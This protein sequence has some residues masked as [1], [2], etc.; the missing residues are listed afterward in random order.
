[1]S[2]L[3]VWV[4]DLARQ[5]A[6]SIKLSRDEARHVTARRLR[7]GD[8]LIV[9][10]GSGRT[11]EA[12][13]ESTTQRSVV[14]RVDLIGET[15]RLDSGFVI[16]SAIPKGDRLGTMLQML[17]QLGLGV[18]QPLIL[19]DSAI[20][21]LDPRTARLQR[22]CL[23]SAK[24]ARRPWRLDIREAVTLDMLFKDLSDTTTVFFGDREGGSFD[25]DRDLAA[26]LMV[27]GPEAGFSESEQKRLENTGAKSVSF[28][29]HNLRIETAAVAA[30]TAANLVKGL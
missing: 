27:I 19:D 17:T 29:R 25:L 13:L 1:M 14:V 28:G 3:W 20:R 5:G 18:W 24:V 12:K 11:A 7:V 21:K 4:E 10:D 26:T 8:S 6:G 15:P 23:E 2:T 30:M 22:I 9:F 16:A